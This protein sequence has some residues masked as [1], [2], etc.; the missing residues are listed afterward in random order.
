MNTNPILP[1]LPLQPPA[2]TP[3]PS[4]A[5]ASTASF[6]DF[7]LESIQQVNGMQQQADKAVETLAVGGEVNMAEV[8]TA[9]Q[10][11]D[12]SFKLMLQ[13]RNKLVQAYEQI[14]DIRI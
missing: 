2:A 7:L 9:V 4:D 11:A 14:K 3:S 1:S 12:M 10:K 6:K 5:G 13:M 8:M